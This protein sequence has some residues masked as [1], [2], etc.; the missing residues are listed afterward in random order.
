[1]LVIYFSYQDFIELGPSFRLDNIGLMV[2]QAISH[3]LVTLAFALL[4]LI[5]FRKYIF[6]ITVL[7]NF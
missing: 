1:V 5:D 4:V 7:N 2:V 3:Y 6:E